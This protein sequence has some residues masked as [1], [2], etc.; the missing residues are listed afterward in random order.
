MTLAEEVAALNEA[1]ADVGQK[2]VAAY[3]GIRDAT[4]AVTKD[5]SD[6]ARSAAA[7]TIMANTSDL[8]IQS[9]RLL[10]IGVEAPGKIVAAIISDTDRPL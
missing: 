7:A 3:V 9:F 8:W 2:M 1:N 4:Q 10:A 5:A 6:E